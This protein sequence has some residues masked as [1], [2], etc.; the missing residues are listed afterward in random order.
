LDDFFTRSGSLALPVSRLHSSKVLGEISPLT[1]SSANLRRWARLLK[2]TLASLL[3][4][5]RIVGPATLLAEGVAEAG[6]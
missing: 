2:G 5:L 6:V 1:S 4:Q 3:G